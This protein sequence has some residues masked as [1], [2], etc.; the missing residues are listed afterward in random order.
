MRKNTGKEITVGDT[1][2]M[3]PKRRKDSSHMQHRL[4]V[5]IDNVAPNPVSKGASWEHLGVHHGKTQTRRIGMMQ[6]M[7][8]VIDM[9]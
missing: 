8:R 4:P 6:V 5:G 9:W 3:K 2:G 7:P 1:C